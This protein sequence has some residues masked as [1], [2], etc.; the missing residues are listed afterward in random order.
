MK[1]L[2]LILPFLILFSKGHAQEIDSTQTSSKEYPYVLPI[3]GQK[4][5]D[6]GYDLPLPFNISIGSV[7]NKQGIILDN[8]SVAFTQGDEMPDFD[9]LQPLADLVEFG[10]SQGRINTLFARAEASILPFLS[11]GFYYGQVWGDQTI[12]LTAPVAIESQT[13][14][15]GLYYGFNLAGFAPLGPVV[16]QADYSRSWT[17]NDRLDRPV[18]VN[19]AGARVIK[20]FVSKKRPDRYLAVWAGAQYQNLEGETS[21]KINL[22]EAL[23]ITPETIDDLDMAW[24]DYMMSPEWGM[25]TPAERVRATAAYTIARNGLVRAEDTTVHYKFTKKLEFE[26]NM[27]LGFQYALNKRWSARAEYGFLQSKQQLF[28]NLVYY[29]GL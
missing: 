18:R 24:E 22:G 29:F 19:V 11:A 25:L 16:L 7:F 9:L 6:K 8:L 2:Y 28:L 23:N 13:E 21:G 15:R 17:T 4:V 10:P 27:L 12:T 3:W 14:I 5:Y 1:K 26:M 20:R